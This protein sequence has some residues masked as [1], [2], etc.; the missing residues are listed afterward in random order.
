MAEQPPEGPPKDGEGEGDSGGPDFGKMA[1]L[2]H[3]FR[4]IF[5]SCI[6]ANK[7][8]EKRSLDFFKALYLDDDGK[9]RTTSID[10]Q[11]VANMVL[12]NH[13]SLSIEELEVE[14]ELTLGDV[15]KG[16]EG[17]DDVDHQMSCD[18]SGASKN[19]AKCRILFKGGD[20]PEG[21][22]RINNSLVKTIKEH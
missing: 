10:G 22:A 5:E 7:A 11:E 12:V 9:P 3:L 21:I 16:D 2:Q 8:I 15:S 17:H 13:Q 4:A 20:P 18:M 6:Q 19:T 1:G 14:F